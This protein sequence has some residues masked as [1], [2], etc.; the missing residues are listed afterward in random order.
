VAEL[1]SRLPQRAYTDDDI[2]DVF[3]SESQHLASHLQKRV[4]FRTGSITLPSSTDVGSGKERRFTYNSLKDLAGITEDSYEFRVRANY[5]PTAS[6]RSLLRRPGID[7][8]CRCQRQFFRSVG[9]LAGKFS[10]TRFLTFTSL[11]Q[12]DTSNTQASVPMFVEVQLPPRQRSLHHLHVG[13]AIRQASLRQTR[14][15]F[16]KPRFAIKYTYSWQ[17]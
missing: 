8:D 17:R 5:R 7:F 3:R 14:R 1:S 13:N 11:I 10:F 12:V 2:A 4:H 16:V 15:R 6:S 9:K